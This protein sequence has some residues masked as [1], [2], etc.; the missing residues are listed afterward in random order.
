MV[1]PVPKTTV[2]PS[3]PDK[4]TVFEAVKVL[5]SAMVSV[6]AVAGAVIVTLLTV[7]A[8]AAPSVGVVKLGET[9][10]AIAPVPVLAVTAT[11]FTRKLLPAP[12][13]SNVLLVSVSVVARPTSVSVV[14][15]SVRVPVLTI[16]PI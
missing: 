9:A 13:V 3:V 14:L 7:V 1:P 16:D 10:R 6:A 11:P 15:G 4:V 5:P 2:D 12:A 8:V